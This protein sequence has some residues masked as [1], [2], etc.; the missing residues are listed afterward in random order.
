MAGRQDEQR[1]DIPGSHKIHDA[2]WVRDRR[3]ARRPRERAVS[4][5][6]G[7]VKKRGL[8]IVGLCALTALA[9]VAAHSS[10][11]F[12]LSARRT[13]QHTHSPPRMSALSFRP[14]LTA[15]LTVRGAWVL[16]PAARARGGGE[17]G[18]R[19]NF[20]WPA[21]AAAAAAAAA[22]SDHAARPALGL[23]ALGDEPRRGAY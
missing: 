23:P 8:G 20:S 21:A 1:Q 5:C 10:L 14:A 12:P 16:G 15:P 11:S 19:E 13:R 4:I 9:A 3:L 2:Q 18:R 7:G 6:E 22:C 17:R